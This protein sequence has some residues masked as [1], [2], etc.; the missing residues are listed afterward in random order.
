MSNDSNPSSSQDVHVDAIAARVAASA[1]D[2]TT[3]AQA[4]ANQD[5]K[6]VRRLE[7]SASALTFG[8]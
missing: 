4:R 7:S 5:E 1:R 3:E 8:G 6:R 2:P